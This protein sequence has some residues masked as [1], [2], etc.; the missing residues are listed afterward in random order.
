M[1][2]AQA[3]TARR[4]DA[5]VA[6]DLTLF[7]DGTAGPRNALVYVFVI[8]KDV[9]EIGRNTA[10]NEHEAFRRFFIVVAQRL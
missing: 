1:A 2:I 4:T 3:D 10:L 8:S 9:T 6:V 7:I 5:I